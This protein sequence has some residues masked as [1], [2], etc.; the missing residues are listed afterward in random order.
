MDFLEFLKENYLWLLVVLIILIIS[1]IG[2]LVD[3]KEKKK[4]KTLEETNKID[5]NA[6]NASVNNNVV[7]DVQTTNVSA[8][9]NIVTPDNVPA[10]EVGTDLNSTPT[11]ENVVN[12]DNVGAPVEPILNQPSPET[13]SA[14]VHGTENKESTPVVENNVP[15]NEVSSDGIFKF[16]GENE[17]PANVQEPTSTEVVAPIENVVPQTKELTPNVEVNTTPSEVEPIIPNVNAVPQA[18][19]SIANEQ[20]VSMEN[21]DIKMPELVQT[22]ESAP[23]ISNTEQ[24]VTDGFNVLNTEVAVDAPKQEEVPVF[25]A[26][27]QPTM[28]P[29][30]PGVAPVPSVEPEPSPVPEVPTP[31]VVTPTPVQEMPTIEPVQAETNPVINETQ[32]PEIPNVNPVEPQTIEPANVG[33]WGNISETTTDDDDLWKL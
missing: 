20:F 32:S 4:K 23:E 9:E 26:W 16:E 6:V 28:A 22:S 17:T 19:D 18:L 1:I 31:E 15:L 14:L 3:K 25:N 10:L 24:V 27:E 8:S 33:D 30:M 29:E 2:F 11:N 13:I 7:P 12:L 5:T 21:P